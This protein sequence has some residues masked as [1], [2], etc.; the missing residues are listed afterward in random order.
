MVKNPYDGYIPSLGCLL[1]SVILQA[2]ATETAIKASQ[3]LKLGY[4]FHGHD[5]LELFGDLPPDMKQSINIVYQLIIQCVNTIR[6]SQ[7]ALEGAIED[8]LIRHRRD[9]EDWRYVHELKDGA[10]I[11]LA[12]LIWATQAIILNF[13]A[14]SSGTFGLDA[15]VQMANRIRGIVDTQ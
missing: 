2:L 10:H 15:N 11:D 7:I 14:I 8:V 13:D 1:S 4:F 6:P 12:D 5:L 3:V 9:F